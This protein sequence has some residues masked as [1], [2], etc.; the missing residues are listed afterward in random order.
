MKTIENPIANV[1]NEV[2]NQSIVTLN[3]FKN[4]KLSSISSKKRPEAKENRALATS[5]LDNW[6][7]VEVLEKIFCDK[8]VTNETIKGI[9]FDRMT[10]LRAAQGIAKLEKE[11][12]KEV[13]LTD[14]ERAVLEALYKSAK[15]TGDS[16]IEYIL[17]NVSAE[18][19][20]S[21]KSVAAT[22][23]SLSLK[24]MVKT[25]SEEDG[26]YF[27]GY[28]TEEGIKALEQKVEKSEKKETKQEKKTEKPAKKETFAAKETK[29]VGDLHKNGKWVWTEY[30]PGK[31]DWRTRPELKQR[32]GAKA[33]AGEEST[34]KGKPAKK[35]A[36][37]AS[38]V[39][40]P[41]KNTE[42]KTS[43]EP[44]QKLL[45]IDEWIALPNKRS[46]VAKKISD[47][48]KEA[49]KLIMKGYRLTSDMKF[50]ENGESRKSCNIESVQALFA[51]YGI[52]YL[53]EGLVK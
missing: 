18:M 23:G 12:A 37:K 34:K 51:R 44:N 21:A 49:F 15:E 38:T 14:N 13:R 27:D 32:P 20:K 28:I 50:F 6:D 39:K 3:E 24:G 36:S 9:V 30:A 48:Q 45:T 2:V 52:N 40:S 17:E 53:P 33:K 43:D 41:V 42:T 26:Y 16:G 4:V 10:A 29:K 25:L 22:I 5:V 46:I 8:E 47:A 35:A 7:N 1:A 11:K 31:F 19:K